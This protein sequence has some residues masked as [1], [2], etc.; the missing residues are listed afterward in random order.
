MSKGEAKPAAK[1]V[2]SVI[3]TVLTVIF[4]AIA[5]FV[6]INLVICKIQKRPVSFF[7]YS[8]AIV[9]TDSMEPE[10]MTGDLIVFR[11]CSINEIKVGDNLVF[12]ADENFDKQVQ[13]QSIVHKV[14][15]IENGVETR[16]VHNGHDDDGFRDADEIYGIC[17]Y[18][19]AGWGKVFSFLGKYGIFIVI[20]LIAGPFIVGQIIKIVKLSKQRNGE[21][22]GVD[23]V[24]EHSVEESGKAEIPENTDTDDKTD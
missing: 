20:A 1:K 4:F 21:V 9:Q 19:S 5:L 6:V 2:L 18:N 23:G 11:R 17:T 12:R 22:N 13:G 10:I 16:G 15:R 24:T 7:G 8:F 3:G 14:V